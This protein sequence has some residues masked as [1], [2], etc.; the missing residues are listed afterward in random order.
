MARKWLVRC[1]GYMLN[2]V[3][4]E[5]EQNRQNI[6]D[7]VTVVETDENHS[8]DSLKCIVVY[9]KGVYWGNDWCFA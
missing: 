7:G 8:V 2:F 4:D 9:L 6:D 3:L 5:Q 1:H